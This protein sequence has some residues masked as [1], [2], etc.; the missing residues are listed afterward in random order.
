MPDRGKLTLFHATFDICIDQ[1]QA[2]GARNVCLAKS[3][4]KRSVVGPQL[5]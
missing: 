1:R 5:G 4:C 3:K 2:M